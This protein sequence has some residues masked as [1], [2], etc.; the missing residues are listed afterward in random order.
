MIVGVDIGT[1]VTK[2]AVIDR[3]GQSVV[4]ASRES[5]LH[6]RSGG[7]VEQDL[8][9]VLASVAEVV[10]EVAADLEE[11]PQAIAITG[12]GDGLWLRDGDGV[13]THPPISWMDARAAGLVESWRVGGADSVVS[14]VHALTGSG[15]FPGCQAALLAHLAEH[16]P[17]VLERSAVAG[18]CCDAVLE[19]LTGVV[20]ID[21]SDASLPFLDV[22]ARTYVDEA[23]ELCGL[24]PWRRLLVDPV[25]PNDLHPLSARG[26][27]LLGLPAGTPVSAGPYDLQACGIGSGARQVGEGTVVLGTTLSCQVLTDDA[28]VQPG[29]EPAGMW[30]CT[31]D[32]DTY[33]RVM[34]SM[35]GMS[36]IDWA[37]RMIGAGDE[38]LD[39][40][41]ARSEPGSG[42]V[43]ALSFLSPAGERAPFVEPRAR[44]EL[45]GITLST[46]PADVV[47]AMCES[48]A[49]AARSCFEVL[50]LDGELSACG[51]GTQ[52]EAL[53]QIFADVLA[54]PVLIP[55]EPL[56]GAR[57]AAAVAWQAMGDPVDLAAWSDDRRVVE[58]TGEGAS[59]HDEGYRRYLEDV[60]H[61]RTAWAR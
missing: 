20:A 29:S 18:Y 24:G 33:L 36:G 54:R 31:P 43:R 15:I 41:L 40:V 44:G 38:H 52:S 25:P 3:D 51:G 13:L 46:S 26:A 61:A 19:Q 59:L 22:R 27:D 37:R 34:P 14:R 49:Y 60:A 12:Q 6:Q 58:P 39:D 1:S 23:V 5:V 50:G 47:R 4:S 9:D 17:D 35:V 55:R 45:T 32:P 28:T 7:R 21:A 10:R 30:L 57:G 8:D 48:V 56:V 16:A 42:G 53:A 2:A 11:A